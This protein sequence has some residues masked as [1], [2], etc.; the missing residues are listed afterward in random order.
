MNAM[1]SRQDV[2]SDFLARAGWGSAEQRPLPADASTRRYIRLQLGGRTALLMDQ[3]Q[4]AETASAPPTASPD[5]RRALG[6]NALARLA[7]AD[8]ARFVA[9]A[10]YL[11]QCGLKS[12]EIHAADITQGFLLIEDLGNDLYTDIIEREGSERDL[13]EAAIDALVALHELPAPASLSPEKPLFE[14][15]EA[16]LLAEVDLLTDWFFPLAL[17]RL[18][19]GSDT[20]EHR[21]LWRR[22]LKNIDGGPSVFVHRDYHAQNLLWRGSL[23]DLARVGIIDFQDAVAGS[24]AYDVISL[25]KDARRDVSPELADAMT[26]RYLKQSR[27]TA[28]ENGRAHFRAAAAVLAAQRNVKIAGIFARLATRDA[29]PRYLAHVPRVWR[30]LERDLQHEVLAPLK[31]WYDEA[32]PRDARN[33]GKNAA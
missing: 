13:Y 33:I 3:P 12:P 11:R 15:D 20:Q 19:D 27:C 26:A 31:Q 24:P 18:A 22:V 10:E 6:Y 8:C 4:N 23:S 28:S 14:Y 5:E 17:G 2:M 32:L 21:A 29:K 30:Y 25:L 7:G 1:R 16:A 9:A